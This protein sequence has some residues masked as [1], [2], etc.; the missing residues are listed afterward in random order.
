M[1]A[2][3]AA[4]REH[5]TGEPTRQQRLRAEGFKMTNEQRKS[6]YYVFLGVGATDRDA[7]GGVDRVSELLGE[8][9]GQPPAKPRVIVD[10]NGRKSVTYEPQ[11]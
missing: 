9:Q 1:R 3:V 7:W 10:C 8:D 4:E 2:V 5:A 6:I 11:R